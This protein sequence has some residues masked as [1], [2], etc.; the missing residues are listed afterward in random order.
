MGPTNRKV[1]VYRAPR[2]YDQKLVWY[3]EATDASG[4]HH[5]GTCLSLS[6]AMAAAY[7]WSKQ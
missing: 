6:G 5:A 2:T 4:D 1:K 7:R 3:W